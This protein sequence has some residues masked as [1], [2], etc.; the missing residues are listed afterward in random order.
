MI[1][2]KAGKMTP[3]YLKIILKDLFQKLI[4]PNLEMINF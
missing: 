3:F 2:A 1:I 4:L